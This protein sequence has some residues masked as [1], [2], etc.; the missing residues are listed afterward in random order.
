MYPFL[1]LLMKEELDQKLTEMKA[2]CNTKIEK[3]KKG[4]NECLTDPSPCPSN[5]TC[6]DLPSGHLCCQYGFDG[7]NCLE[8]PCS[9]NPCGHGQCS[10]N[11]IEQTW[12]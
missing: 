2:V 6:V 5:D 7:Q 11:Q 10:P 8:N 3:L 4:I 1:D 9:N 12:V